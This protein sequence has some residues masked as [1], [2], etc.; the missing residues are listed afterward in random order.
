[1]LD[2]LVSKPWP[3]LGHVEIANLISGMAPYEIL[4]TTHSI[5]AMLSETRACYLSRQ[6]YYE[7]LKFYV[8][9]A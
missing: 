3:L 2:S 9:A 7:A 5:T 1:M 6:Q 8:E 4:Y